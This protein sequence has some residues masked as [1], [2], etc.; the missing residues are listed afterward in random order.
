LCARLNVSSLPL[1][2]AVYTRIR[3]RESTGKFVDSGLPGNGAPRLQPPELGH[4]SL[5]AAVEHSHPRC[6]RPGPNQHH[7]S[8][9]EHGPARLF[10][11][12]GGILQ[13][14]GDAQGGGDDRTTGRY[15]IMTNETGG[16]EKF[17]IILC[18]RQSRKV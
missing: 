5:P 18:V 13:I 16:V 3:N 4:A 2:V 11:T 10:V 8:E 14:V 12:M 6:G 15:L 7:A 17:L 9:S 1:R